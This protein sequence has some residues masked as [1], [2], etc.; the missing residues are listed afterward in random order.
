MS[1]IS[2]LLVVS[3]LEFSGMGFLQAIASQ[4]QSPPPEEVV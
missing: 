1:V 2:F 3:K 4:G